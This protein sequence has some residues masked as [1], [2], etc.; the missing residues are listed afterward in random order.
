M[1]KN[2]LL[3]CS[4]RLKIIYF[5][6]AINGCVGAVTAQTITI[7][8][9]GFSISA[10]PGIVTG[11]EHTY[12]NI[13]VDGTFA[14]EYRLNN[15]IGLTAATGFYDLISKTYQAIDAH[16]GIR[17]Q[18]SS[19]DFGI[20][21]LKGGIK[22]FVTKQIFIKAEGGY[23]FEVSPLSG[24]AVDNDDSEYQQGKIMVS[25]GFGYTSKY[26]GIGLE[27]DVFYATKATGYHYNNFG[28][29]GLIF[30]YNL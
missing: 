22:I 7:N 20:V 13:A 30:S 27:Y 25:P 14:V 4:L 1:F 19:G 28:I 18:A 9:L 10:G 3:D 11:Y 5:I 21:P 17:Y 24:S 26:W 2:E 15:I 23:A 6:I 12:R 29:A 8:K 16:A